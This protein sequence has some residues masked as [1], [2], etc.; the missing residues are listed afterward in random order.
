MK[1]QFSVG[2]ASRNLSSMTRFASGHSPT[3]N[4]CLEIVLIFG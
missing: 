2:G 1:D 3:L 4:A